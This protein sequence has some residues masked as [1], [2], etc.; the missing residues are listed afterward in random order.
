[1]LKMKLSTNIIKIDK[2]PILY[3]ATKMPI[4][5]FTRKMSIKK[6]QFKYK[7]IVLIINWQKKNP[8]YCTRG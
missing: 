7:S 2:M 6:L 4:L 3:F 1:M 8:S 5:Y